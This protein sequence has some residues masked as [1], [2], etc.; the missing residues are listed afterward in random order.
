MDEAH[1]TTTPPSD[2]NVLRVLRALHPL[3]PEHGSTTLL[4]GL[5]GC[6][7]H[8]RF[9][10]IQ[11]CICLDAHDNL[12]VAAYAGRPALHP[13]NAIADATQ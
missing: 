13:Q 1:C 3:L 5:L 12:C 4:R 11:P 8:T 10:T 2:I 6:W 9:G 7:Q